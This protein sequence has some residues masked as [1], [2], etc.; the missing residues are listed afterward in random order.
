LLIADDLASTR[1][2]L[3][4]VLEDDDTFEVVGEATNG[5]Q[6]V[7]MADALQPDI[8]LLDVGMPEMDGP[9]ALAGI[10]AAAPAAKVVILSGLNERAVQPLLDAGATTFVPKGIAPLDLLARLQTISPRA[11][12]VVHDDDAPRSSDVA[13]EWRDG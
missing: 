5:V 10:L 7:A 3:R 1:R 9:D 2:F 4:A 12:N 8:V 6:A 11:A 13:R